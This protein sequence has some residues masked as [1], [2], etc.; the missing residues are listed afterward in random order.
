MGFRSAIARRAQYLIESR[1]SQ[2]SDTAWRQARALR[3]FVLLLRA[4]PR[5]HVNA[6]AA[7]RRHAGPH[8]RRKRDARHRGRVVERG[9]G[10]AQAAPTATAPATAAATAAQCH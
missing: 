7:R 6:N 1:S 2:S 4:L 10:V 5:L 3:E 8:G 9:A